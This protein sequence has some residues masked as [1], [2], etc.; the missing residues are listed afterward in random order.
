MT[1]LNAHEKADR[2]ANHAYFTAAL[3]GFAEE[4]GI[5]LKKF[6]DDYHYRLF[7]DV[8]AT[9]DIWPSTGKFYIKD[10]PMGRGFSTN[11]RIG[12]LPRDYNELDSWLRA[13]FGV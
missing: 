9:I 2:R 5:E 1:K 12:K 11:E 10:I 8:S 7:D 13:L 6:N 3:E 4:Y